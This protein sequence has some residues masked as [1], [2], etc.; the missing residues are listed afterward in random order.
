MIGFHDGCE[1]I[2][3]TELGSADRRRVERGGQSGTLQRRRG[4]D[5]ASTCCLEA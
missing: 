1:R 4:Q 2:D 5:D 3:V